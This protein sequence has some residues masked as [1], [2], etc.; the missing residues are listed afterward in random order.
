MNGWYSSQ[1]L[2]GLPG[3]PGTDRRVR[4]RLQKNLRVARTKVR[5]KGLEWP[6][7]CLPPETRDALHQRELAKLPIAVS[8]AP[9]FTDSSSPAP[10]AAGVLPAERP[11]RQTGLSIPPDLTGEHHAAKTRAQR[12][13][14]TARKVILGRVTSLQ[15]STGCSQEAALVTLLTHA[16]ATGELAPTLAHAR[17]KRGRKGGRD[18]GL[19]SVRSLKR[20][21][22]KSSSGADLAPAIPQK[23]WTLKPWHAQVY[24]L[25]RRPQGGTLKWVHEQLLASWNPAHGEPPSY[26]AVAR[27]RREKASQ[28]DL[29]DGRHTGMDLKAHKR[30]QIRSK[31]GLWP[32]MEVHADGWCTHFT[33]PH[34]VSGEYVTYEVWTAIDFATNYP[35]TPAFGLAESY[36]VIAKCLENAVRDIGVPA[37]W[38]I[39]NTKSAKNDRFEL[40]SVASLQ[41]RLGMTVVHPKMLAKGK[42]NSQANGLIENLHAWYDRE[43]REL[44]TYQ[45][46]GMDGLTLKRVKRIT[47]KMAK[48]RDL[49]ERDTLK[50]EAER[51]GKGVVFESFEAAHAWFMGKIEK[52]R[53]TPSRG[54]PKLRDPQTGKLRHQTPREA[55][56]QARSEGWEP[57]VMTDAEIADAFR[58]HVKKTVK[59]GGVWAYTGHRYDHAELEDWNNK[60]VMVAIDLHDWRTV[61][62][63]TLDGRLIVE[64]ALVEARSPRPMSMYEMAQT[65]RRESQIKRR[66]QQIDAINAR[67]ETPV[68][69]VPWYVSP[70]LEAGRPYLEGEAVE[71]KES[72]AEL[73]AP[74]ENVIAMPGIE[75]RPWFTNDP[76]QYRWLMRNL[77]QWDKSDVLWLLDYVGTD[78]YLDI[79]PRYEMQGV[80]WCDA[81]AARARAKLEGFEVAAG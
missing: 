11:E 32:A 66:E 74:A 35:C 62:I 33:A 1:E 44:A 63:K 26:D 6:I 42:G 9:T 78:D 72:A 20:W 40:D 59:R 2:V 18:D 28:I 13:T 17:D 52:R 29:L 51:A 79:L 36:E 56:E 24:S 27:F 10:S 80:V 76:D 70:V 15:H 50:R 73:A 4:A 30:Y 41:A 48:S 64:A 38:Q 31:A 23:D 46:K 58:P 16:R 34:P 7:S 69:D 8:P 47:A 12:E 25:L 5:G 57:I 71:I 53:D 3:M 49:V 55:L 45:G 14:E 67:T 68:L 54:L 39:D 75:K 61:W 22:S 65:K 43:A 81:D 21:L 19:P 60:E 77:A 37:I